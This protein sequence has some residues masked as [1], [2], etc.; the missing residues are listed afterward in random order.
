MDIQAKLHKT[1]TGFDWDSGSLF[2]WIMH[3]D[4][5]GVY[6]GQTQSDV[7][8]EGDIFIGP[9]IIDGV[10]CVNGEPVVPLSQEQM[11]AAA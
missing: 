7:M 8:G 11:A 10:P 6:R 5:N 3:Y 4:A 1:A 2:T 9:E